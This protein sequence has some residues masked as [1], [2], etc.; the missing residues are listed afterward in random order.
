[1]E[2]GRKFQWWASSLTLQN[3]LIQKN[4]LAHQKRKMEEA[5]NIAPCCQSPGE[6]HKYIHHG[7][8]HMPFQ[9]K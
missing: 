9:K 7:L 3:V 8:I 2:R 4:N 6:V 1:M 5:D